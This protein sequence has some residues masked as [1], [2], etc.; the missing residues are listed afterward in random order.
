MPTSAVIE[1]IAVT[2]ELC[3]R[4]FSPAAAAVFAADLDGF[5]EAAVLSALTRCRK[6]VRGLMTLQ[7]V[8]SRIDD[9]RPGVEEAWAMLPMDEATTVVWTEEM[10]QA[11]GLARPLLTAGDRIAARMAFKEHYA[12]A[13]AK[14]R[15]E[16]RPAK[17]TASLGDD[18]YGREPVLLEAVQKGRL[19]PAHVKAL[20][21]YHEISPQAV[22]LLERV[23]L[24]L[25][26]GSGS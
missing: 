22:A 25:I 13:I 18:K 11:W 5:P 6:E 3:G 1:A 24:K 26:Q 7:D 20:L 23:D 17:W 4:T 21:P 16:R 15:D 9:G 14:A 12:A 8:V 19:P 2:A 10:A